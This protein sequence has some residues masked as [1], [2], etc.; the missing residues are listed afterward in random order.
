MDIINRCLALQEFREY[1]KAY[2]FGSE[3]AN[4]LVVHHTWKPTKE[5]WAG[6][7]SIDGLKR[8]YEKK[9]WPVGPHLFIAEEGIWLFTPMR[10]DGIHAAGLNHCSIGIEVVGDYDAE[11]WSGGTKTNAL[12]A[13]K[14]LMD[15]LLLKDKDIYFH[16]DISPKSC[17]G[18]A[19]TKE[20]LF[21]ELNNSYPKSVLA[22][23]V[24]NTT[25]PPP[26]DFSQE[27]EMVLIQVPDWSKEAVDFIAKHKLFKIRCAE[28]VRHAV[29]FYRFYKLIREHHE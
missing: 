17:P 27:E 14:A 1:V 3:P 7:K 23:I 6:Q 8:Y 12:G 26:V 22:D 25:A 5:T 16:R 28:D 11:V 19:I 9:K 10:Q 29:R 21:Q 24:R 2:Y 20:W 4:K 18:R 15:R 13:I